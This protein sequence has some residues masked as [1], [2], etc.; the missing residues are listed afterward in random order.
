MDNVDIDFMKN[1][2]GVALDAVGEEIVVS[3]LST[4]ESAEVKNWEEKAEETD[5]PETS[6]DLTGD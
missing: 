5:A 2:D 1:A 3:S 4:D 6:K